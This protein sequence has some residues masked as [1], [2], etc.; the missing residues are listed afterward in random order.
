MGFIM[1]YHS[2]FLKECDDVGPGQGRSVKDSY[3]YPEGDTYEGEW[4]KEGKKHGLGVLRFADGC[5]YEGRFAHGLFHG[6]GTL[7]FTDGTTY[8]GEFRDGLFN[9]FGVYKRCDDTMF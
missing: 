7:T 9:G 8:Q 3:T 5:T 4:S 6:N 2:E 1:G